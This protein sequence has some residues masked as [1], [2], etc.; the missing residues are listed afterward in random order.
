MMLPFS[1]ITLYKKP[2]CAGQIRHRAVTFY[3]LII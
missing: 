2:L 1:D 3:V